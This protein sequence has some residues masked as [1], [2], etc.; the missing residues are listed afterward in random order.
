MNE[1][2]LFTIFPTINLENFI[3]RKISI[4]HDYISYF[5][6][7]STPPVMEYLSE[8][9]IPINL[10]KARSDLSYWAKLFDYQQSFYWAIALKSTNQ[11]IGTCGFNYWNKTHKRAEISYDLDYNHWGKGI[12]TKAVK[13]ISNYAFEHT[14]IQRI[15]ATVASDNIPSIRVLEKTGYTKEGLMKKFGILHGKSKDFYMYSLFQTT[16]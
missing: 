3:L 16:F 5:N 15:Q 14:K 10:D 11:I 8:D 4:E 13:L 2:K 1:D 12:M 6:Y 7:M 9:D